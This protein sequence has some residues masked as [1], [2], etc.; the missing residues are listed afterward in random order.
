MRTKRKLMLLALMAAGFVGSLSQNLLTAALPTILADFGVSTSVGQWLT[1][2]YILVLGVIT[3]ASAWLFTRFHTKG[4]VLVSLAVFLGGCVLAFAAGN[5]YVLLAARVVQAFG[6]GALIPL[7][8]VAVLHLYPPEKQGRALGLTGIV[9]GFAPAVGPTLSGLLID[10]FG[11]RS[12]FV[13]LILLSAVIWLLAAC[14]VEE[15]GERAAERLDAL[16]LLLYGLGFVAWMLGVTLLKN[17][18]VSAAAL[19]GLFV[20]GGAALAWFT[21]RQLSAREPLLNLRLLREPTLRC[22]TLLLGCSYVL[23][24]TGTI[25]LPLYIQTLC[26]YSATASGLIL[27]PGS[28]LI[29]LLSP[30]VGA[31]CDRYGA[32]RLC[33][34]GLALLLLGNTPFACFRETTGMALVCAVYAVRSAGLAVLITACTTLGVQRLP[35]ADKSHGTAILNSLRQISGSL[36]S[37][38]LVAVASACSA[39][40]D[41]SV[42]G[43]RVAFALM[44]ALVLAALLYSARPTKKIS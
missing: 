11:W 24:M 34:A 10:G 41:L 43:F 18:G 15:L 39:P 31:W 19:V 28:L 32:L 1:T 21:R 40:A 20:L 33:V 26:G 25:L 12:I 17:G 14:S 9:V 44:S 35:L 16:S 23:M 13:F 5:F 37:T 7:L 3:A 22:G 38:V 2:I 30:M 6:A 4:L 8:Q 27:L 42:R 29:A 36:F